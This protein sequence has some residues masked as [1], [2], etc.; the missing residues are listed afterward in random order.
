MS[1]LQVFFKWCVHNRNL[2]LLFSRLHEE[3]VFQTKKILKLEAKIEFFE[4]LLR[5][6]SKFL[7]LWLLL[8]AKIDSLSSAIKLMCL[9][10]LGVQNLLSN[11]VDIISLALTLRYFHGVLP[12]EGMQ[13]LQSI[14]VPVTPRTGRKYALVKKATTGPGKVSPD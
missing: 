4:P 10:V 12:N 3:L 9:W 2:I 5:F 11:K 6:P 14:T 7:S 1:A 8:K 13:H